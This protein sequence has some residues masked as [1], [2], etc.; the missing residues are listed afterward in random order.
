[1]FNVLFSILNDFQKNL[2]RFVERLFAYFMLI[3]KISFLEIRDQ[4]ACPNCWCQMDLIFREI[5]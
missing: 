4:N 3:R 5:I 2:K 1:M